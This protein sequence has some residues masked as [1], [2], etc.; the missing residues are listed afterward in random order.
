ILFVRD[1][2][3]AYRGKIP[4]IGVVKL[5]HGNR[6]TAYNLLKK[7]LLFIFVSDHLR[8]LFEPTLKY[9]LP[10]TKKAHLYNVKV[11]PFIDFRNN[12]LC[13]PA[14]NYCNGITLRSAAMAELAGV[15]ARVL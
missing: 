6:V 7:G 5:L 15:A 3:R 4:R 2:T 9:A 14:S 11:Q 13:H 10:F 1:V 8:I 12:P